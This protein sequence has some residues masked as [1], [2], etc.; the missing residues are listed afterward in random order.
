MA[1]WLN[2][3]R[4]LITS[5]SGFLSKSHILPEGLVNVGIHYRYH[6]SSLM[7]K[8]SRRHEFENAGNEFGEVIYV[9]ENEK[10]VRKVWLGQINCAHCGKPNSVRV[11]KETLE[12]AVPAET[13]IRVIVEKSLQTVLA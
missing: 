10:K 12:P 11:E 5:F 2:H 13:E 9:S 7:G 8:S 6:D 4:A 1:V 3:S